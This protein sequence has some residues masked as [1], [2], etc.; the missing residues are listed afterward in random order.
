MQFPDREKLDQAIYVTG[1]YNVTMP[2]D[3]GDL[4]ATVLV[5]DDEEPVADLYETY[6]KDR[7]E[8]RVAYGG[9]AALTRLDDAVDV[10]L[11][12]RRM[13]GL[14][15]DDVLERIR[16]R[17]PD[18]RVVMVTALDPDFDI[19]EMPFDEYLTKPV[20]ESEIVEAVEEQLLYATYDN[21]LRE[22]FRIKSKID[23]LREQKPAEELEADDRFEELCVL[24][25]SIRDDIESL[26]DEYGE[27]DPQYSR[28]IN[29][30][31]T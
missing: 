12:D 5:V 20:Q 16:D 29:E 30:S 8:V 15:G 28:V 3:E 17:Q 6:L 14:S 24:A 7:Y 26:V 31:D 27:I 22:Y 11:L 19:V 23:V 13:P 18:C 4:E 1:W 10:V 21:R 9:R 25:D 2:T